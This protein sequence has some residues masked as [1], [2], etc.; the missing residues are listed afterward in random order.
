MPPLG[1]NNWVM[2]PVLWGLLANLM[3]QAL[4]CVIHSSF[5]KNDT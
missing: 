5:R 3:D 4:F 1:L 2:I